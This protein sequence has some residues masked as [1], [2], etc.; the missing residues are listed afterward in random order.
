MA[1]SRRIM[2]LVILDLLTTQ[3]ADRVVSA[4]CPER[5]LRGVRD[6]LN[7]LRVSRFLEYDQVR[8]GSRYR[9]RECLLTAVTTKADVVTKQSQRH[10]SS[11]DGTTTK[12]GSP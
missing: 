6:T 2:P 4:R 5:K 7:H 1:R 11:P 3:E 8:S 12:Y 10:A 9:F